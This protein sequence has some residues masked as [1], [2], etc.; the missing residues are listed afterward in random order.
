MI[1][2][3]TTEERRLLT[4]R[5]RRERNRKVCDRIKAVLM[6]DD[7]YSYAEIA[8]VLLIDDETVRR[9]IM[10]YF[11]ALGKKAASRRP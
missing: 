7:G 11:K 9:H 6:H 3:L 8:R 4:H 10:D 5:H 2:K 1:R